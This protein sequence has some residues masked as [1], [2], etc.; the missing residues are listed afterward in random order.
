MAR[1]CGCMG[2]QCSMWHAGCAAP[3]RACTPTC[4]MCV[5]CVVC[6]EHA[7]AA[8]ACQFRAGPPAMTVWPAPPPPPPAGATRFLDQPRGVAGGPQPRHG[9]LRRSLSAAVHAPMRAQP[10]SQHAPHALTA[11]GR[12]LRSCMQPFFAVR[13]EAWRRCVLCSNCVCVVVVVGRCISS[14]SSHRQQCPPPPSKA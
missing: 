7:D 2:T 11:A 10:C 4:T 9:A 8:F 6:P 1:R 14:R 13:H 12:C 5:R 3:A